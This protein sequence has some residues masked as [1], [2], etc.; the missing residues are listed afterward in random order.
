MEEFFKSLTSPVWWFSVVIV[1]IFISVI[2]AYLKEGIDK[3]LSLLS[4]AWKLNVERNKEKHLELLRLVDS[5]DRI[6]ILLGLEENRFRLRSMLLY[7]L[8]IFCLML[9]FQWQADPN[10][11]KYLPYL[12]VYG[13]GTMLAS[14]L[15]LKKA[16]KIKSILYT[17]KIN[18]RDYI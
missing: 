1:G 14:Y 11:V 6:L 4:S 3:C 15:Y 16:I 8:G 13:G 18:P 12:N 5:S 7:I 9:I 17:V 2:A 10:Y